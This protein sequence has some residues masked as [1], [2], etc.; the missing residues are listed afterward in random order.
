MFEASISELVASEVEGVEL[1]TREGLAA[2]L[3]PDQ[4]PQRQDWRLEVL[5]RGPTLRSAFFARPADP[6]AS[7]GIVGL[8][9]TGV[10]P[11]PGRFAGSRLQFDAAAHEPPMCPFT[12]ALR[13]SVHTP[14][15][16]D[17]AQVLVLEFHGCTRALGVPLSL[18]LLDEEEDEDGPQWA[19]QPAPEEAPLPAPRE[20]RFLDTGLTPWEARMVEEDE[21]WRGPTDSRFGDSLSEANYLPRMLA[22][23]NLEEAAR[24]HI[25]NANA[26][27]RSIS[28]P[29]LLSFY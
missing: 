11:L 26:A 8:A 16:G 2:V 18:S 22:L 17:Y 3:Y 5:S 10:A 13:V 14:S 4:L 29:P 27:I 6:C 28:F 24:S 15:P 12:Y 23:L 1:V 20:I 9:L 25:L 21:A 7:W 19:N